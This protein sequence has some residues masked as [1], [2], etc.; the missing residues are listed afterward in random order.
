MND[1]ALRQNLA[2]LIAEDGTLVFGAEPA[3]GDIALPAGASLI[4]GRVL[5]DDL[6]ILLYREA[7]QDRLTLRA[8]MP[9]QA[10][11]ERTKMIGS[12]LLPALR[13]A[14]QDLAARA[15]EAALAA[16]CT[17][18]AA[19][20]V[21]ASLEIETAGGQ[22]P[23]QIE[24]RILGKPFYFRARWERWSV[25]IGGDPVSAPEWSMSQD[26]G[27]MFSAGW[28]TLGEARAFLHHAIR[29]HAA[30]VR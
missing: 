8:D 30:G 6:G 16:A 23:V 29:R 13:A 22:C 11:A 20:P 12:G 25:G 1:D 4:F 9:N 18:A 5:S 14:F 15:P 19:D 21:L 3:P 28:M 10:E 17:M 27:P 26:Y 7:G 24:G 2:A